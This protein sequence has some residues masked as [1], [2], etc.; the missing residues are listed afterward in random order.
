[1]ENVCRVL[2][3]RE[4]FKCQREELRMM[5]GHILCTPARQN[6]TCPS[7]HLSCTTCTF[8]GLDAQNKNSNTDHKLLRLFFHFWIKLR[9]QVHLLPYFTWKQLLSCL[10]VNFP[11][12]ISPHNC[13]HCKPVHTNVHSMSLIQRPSFL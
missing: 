2:S 8:W 5:R 4:L 10:F 7:K 3:C 9:F 12:A 13:S 1:M 11:C 6:S